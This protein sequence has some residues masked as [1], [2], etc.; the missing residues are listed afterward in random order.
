MKDVVF[1]GGVLPTLS[2][3]PATPPNFTFI[4]RVRWGFYSVLTMLR[5]RGNW[6]RALPADVRD[7]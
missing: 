7:G 3:M 2:K 5:A 1:Q 6:N 4:S